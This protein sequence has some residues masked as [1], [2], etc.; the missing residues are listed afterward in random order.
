PLLEDDLVRFSGHLPADYLVKGLKLRWFFKEA[1]RDLLPEEI[2][3]KKK[4]GFGLPFGPWSVSHAPLRELVGDSLSALTRR[5]WV[6]KDYLDNIL[7]HQQY[8][9]AGYYGIMIWVAMILE[10]WLE[11]HNH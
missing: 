3:N 11:A 8:T 1:L 6:R 5:G 7:H 2:I 9:H 10:Q 4:H